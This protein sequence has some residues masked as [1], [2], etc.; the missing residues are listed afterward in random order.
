MKRFLIT[1]VS[2]R[3]KGGSA[4]VFSACRLI[5][6]QG[7]E[8]SLISFHP[9]LDRQALKES[10]VDIP[11]SVIPGHAHRWRSIAPRIEAVLLVIDVLLLTLLRGHAPLFSRYARHLR[12]V[13]GVLEIHGI[14]FSDNYGVNDALNSF[15]SM[16][17]ARLMG[18]RYYCL[19]Q[20]YGPSRSRLVRTLA[21]LGLENCAVVMPRGHF[22]MQFI[23][24]L[25]LRHPQVIFMPDLAFSYPNPSETLVEEMRRR[26]RMDPNRNYVA[27]IPNI[28][29]IKWGYERS[30]QVY[31]DLMEKLALALDCHFLLIP[32]EY[33]DSEPDDR[34]F[35]ARIA[36]TCAL[37]D[38]LI[39][40]DD[41]LSADEIKALLAGCS[42]TICSR[43]HGM[44]SSLK[45]GVVPFVIGW[46]DK[47]LEIMALFDL[48]GNVRD[49]RDVDPDEFFVHMIGQQSQESKIRDVLAGL[50]QSLGGLPGYI[51]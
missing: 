50:E 42:L 18:V 4:M 20:S 35:N 30:V 33:S 23:G 46:A 9:D 29:F 31:V 27:I 39:R 22:S 26:Y 15:L 47:Y 32:H 16:R 44:V 45:M 36:E 7:V 48:D 3:S 13:D 5:G 28:L 43:F 10:E 49:Y 41:P 38:R 24:G 17:T 8:Y 37:K 11:L 34:A 51:R 12:G 14:S 25:G 1:G 6:L 40:I 21:R 2:L 19:P